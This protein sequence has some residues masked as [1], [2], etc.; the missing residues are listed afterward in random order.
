MRKLP[1]PIPYQGSKRNIATAIFSYLPPHMHRLVEPFSGS[2]AM[3]IFAADNG[4]ANR[5]H[6]N[7]LNAPLIA[8]L[9]MIVNSPDQIAQQYSDLWHEQLGQERQFYDYVRGQF[10][11]YHSPH[12][13]LFL[14]A[15]CVK[16]SV[17]YNSSG[18]FNQGPDNRRRG[19]H[20][21]SMRKDILA[22][23]R[24]LRYRTT[25]SQVNYTDIVPILEPSAD[26]VY[27][28]PPYQGTS[29]QRD[30]RY[31]SGINVKEFIAFLHELNKRNV[32][33]AVSYDGHKAGKRYGVQLPDELRLVH[34]EINA[35]RSSQS[36]LLGE[37]H[38]T[39]ESLYL[40]P[41]LVEQLARF[42]LADIGPAEQATLELVY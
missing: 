17:R 21:T 38:I 18:A 25:F 5:F 20:P 16:A 22:V 11:L 33:Y 27:M 2:A 39:F 37:K 4:I 24:L 9:D 15:R 19:R 1:Q 36:T 29:A 41:P 26:L 7:D 10:N 6:L 32:M 35:G 13:L 34:V 28:D 30:R 23:S 3:S 14:L 8:L 42:S 40:S 12:H 31:L